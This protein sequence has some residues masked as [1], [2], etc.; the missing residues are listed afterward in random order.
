VPLLTDE[1]WQSLNK[2][3]DIAL[4]L[5]DAERD[6]WLSDLEAQDPEMAALVA[7]VLEMRRR[8]DFAEFLQSDLGVGASAVATASMA[9]RSVGPYVIDA[10]IGQGGMGTVWR[11]RRAD[12]RFEGTVAIK[13][14]HTLLVGAAGE[15]RFRVEGELLARLDHPN[16]AR[17]IDAGVMEAM[18]PY[19]VLEYVEGE[20]IDAY[21]QKEL[22]SLEARV[23]LFRHVLAAVSHA[24]SHLVVHR[25]IKPANILVTGQG[26]VKLLD[27]GIAKLLD[28]DSEAVPLTRSSVIP[29][30]PQY[31]APEQALGQE[32]T[33]ATD[34]YALG[35]VLYLL[36][37]GTHPVRS[38][39]RSRTELLH[40]VVT[41]DAPRASTATTI[42]TVSRRALE[43][44]LDNILGKALKKNPAERYQSV[45]A[46]SDDLR[47]FLSHEP[48]AARPDSLTYRTRKF[49]RR[50][51]GAVLGAILTLITLLLTSAVALWQAHRADSERDAAL[52]AARRA[53]S[54]G[55]FM[56][57]LLS[58]LGKSNSPEAQREHLDRARALLKQQHY[59]DPMVSANLLHYLAARYEEFGYSTPAIEL[60]Q[61]A[62]S[63]LAGTKEKIAVGQLGCQLANLYDDLGREND[64][65][66]EIRASMNIL[67]S[68]GNAV[69]P[70]ELADCR[71][72]A[73]YV[74]TARH[75]NAMAISSAQKSVDELKVA[76]LRSGV[77]YVTAL[78][79][80]ARAQ[81]YA[82]H[83]AIAVDVM[84]QI[85]NGESERGTP[86]TIGAWIH[87]FNLTRYLMAGGRVLEAEKMATALAMANSGYNNA[88]D[89]GLLRAKLLL[90][91]DRTEEATRLLQDST[92]GVA[93]ERAVTRI[94]LLLRSGDAAGAHREWSRQEAAI[95]ALLDAKGENAVDALRVKALL[96]MS[97]A[98]EATA[99]VAL[100]QAADLAID[101]DGRPAP[102]L[103]QIEALRAED[104]LKHG[105]IA[106]ACDSAR[107]A[108]ARA[109]AEAVNADSSAWIGEALLLRARCEQARGLAESMHSSARAALPHL[110][111]NL[112][113]QHPLAVRARA[114]LAT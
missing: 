28:S 11:A 100:K 74:E 110:E 24:H 15:Q 10:E 80:L 14:V 77:E 70:Q 62:K 12:G 5:P 19:L 84:R 91:L 55:D 40:A 61:E 42:A 39:T 60:L 95:E 3:L 107:I 18:Q 68:S 96:A 52:L 72:V 71:E 23:E 43:G 35:L 48:V 83:Y 92:S 17:L 85:R 13:F 29:L 54:V 81:A 46:F 111:Q 21:C 109:Q 99:R 26:V 106:E 51:R 33:T 2:Y 49:V 38:N 16:I 20:P 67:E 108:V 89:V 76:G 79:A 64:A 104:S 57:T 102:G 7:R 53:D 88:R 86:Q 97:D 31:A 90:A 82:G 105:A 22:L 41:E 34:V 58:D 113:V 73:S 65:D 114:L 75:E 30:T 93:A 98:D 66:R 87:E 8:Q 59:E 101:A 9:G 103:R 50:H 32:I 63:G 47:R 94:E 78:N 112:G 37:T 6:S 1:H 44:D 56:S 45:S 69:R 25:D 36:L 27:F 4:E